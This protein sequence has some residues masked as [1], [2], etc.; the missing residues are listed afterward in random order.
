[1]PP[2]PDELR[3][4]GGVADGKRSHKSISAEKKQRRKEAK[5]EKKKKKAGAGGFIVSAFQASSFVCSCSGRGK[6]E[7]CTREGCQGAR[8]PRR[9]FLRGFELR[10]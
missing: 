9:E 6:K 10:D 5:K 8:V 1:M 2:N 3:K 4:Q 7:G